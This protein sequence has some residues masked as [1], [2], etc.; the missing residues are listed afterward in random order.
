MKE[1]QEKGIFRFS[2]IAPL[3]NNTHGFDTEKEYLDFVASKTYHFNGKNYKFSTSCIRNWYS[4]YKKYG[5]TSLEGKTRRD[6]KSSRKLTNETIQRMIELR[7]NYPKITGKAIYKILMKESFIK[8]KDIS[9][10]TIQRYLKKNNLKRNEVCNIERRTFEMEHV[11]DCWQ[12]DTSSGPYILINKKKYRT[13]IIMFIDDKSRMIMGYDIFLNDNAINM[14]KVFKNAIKTYGKPKRLFV[15]NGGPYDNKQLS[16]ICA[17]LGIELIHAKPYTPEAK[18]KQERLFRTIK[19][20]WMNCTDWNT[21]QSLEDIKESLSTF[22]YEEYMN[23]IHSVTKD[24]PNERWH[25]EL[26]LV[27]FLDESIIDESFLHRGDHKVR[28]DRTIKFNNELYEVPFEYVGKT[29]ETRYNP[30]DLEVLYIYEENKRICEI[31][32]VDK[33]ANSKIKRKNSIDYSR[34]INDERDVIES[35]E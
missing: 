9:L 19:D 2:I 3:I 24:S 17:S 27:N 6:Y 34:A 8:E 4:K 16:Y 29:I 26:K 14:Q 11:N 7:T 20:G 33:V 23:H 13:Y 32:K 31:K 18:A 28:L 22:L 30:L 5:I 12:A 25:K 35:E 21:F 1:Q 15:D 10:S